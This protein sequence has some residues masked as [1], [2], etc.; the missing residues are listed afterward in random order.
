MFGKMTAMSTS[1]PVRPGAEPY[2]AGDGRYGVLLC[3]GFTGSPA[4]MRPWAEYLGER[5]Y[6][7]RVPRL[8]GHGTSWQEMNTTTW[9]QWY[10]E[11]DRALTELRASCEWTAV[12]GLSM[13]GGLALRLAE[14]RPDEV[15]ALVLVN[16][17]VALKRFD[18]K[19]LPVLRRLT[20]SFPGISNDIAKP[21][22]DE[23]AYDRVPL[24]ALAQQLQLWR[25]IRFYLAKVRA[26]MLYFRSKVDHTVDELS[27]Q[28]I[29]D[30]VSSSVREFVPLENSYHVATLDYDAELIFARSAEFLAEYAP[31]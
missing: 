7:V 13:G 22:Q 21:G 6:T 24:H 26:P 3:H 18:L 1:S 14:N 29:L 19:L 10:A 27:Q 31:S 20:P 30:G 4:A 12:C 8:P 25:D 16:P 23:V 28:L 11:V 5:G 2:A 15:G 17:A 9:Q